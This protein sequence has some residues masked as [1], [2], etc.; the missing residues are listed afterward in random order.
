MHPALAC[1]STMRCSTPYHCTLPL[2]A[3]APCQSICNVLTLPS[4]AAPAAHF[5]AAAAPPEQTMLYVSPCHAP[6]TRRETVHQ[7]RQFPSA[8]FAGDLPPSLPISELQLLP[9]LSRAP[10]Q[11]CL[12]VAM[13]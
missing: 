6:R 11:E 7:E 1:P 8:V 12:T 2:L 5:R 3:R 13:P 9:M 4:P 10:H